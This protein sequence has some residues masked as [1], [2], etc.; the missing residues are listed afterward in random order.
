MPLS[1]TPR[2]YT[3]TAMA[4]HWVMALG[5]IGAIAVGWYASELP[6]SLARLK[7]IN[8]HKWFGITLLLLFVVRFAWR[9]THR[10]PA[11]VPAPLWQA[12]AA[13]AVHGLLYV[14]MAAVP[15][16]GWA[17]SNAAGFP[18]VWFGVLPLPDWVGPNKELAETLKGLHKIAAWSL[19]VL[20]AAHVG[21]ALKHQLIDRDRLLARMWPGKD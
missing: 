5:L 21:A 12:R 11:E 9:A 18:V 15:L 6:M 8:W 14:L 10:P 13:H 3:R 19:A 1:S 20:I 2:R 16:L 4:L 7:L 17:Y